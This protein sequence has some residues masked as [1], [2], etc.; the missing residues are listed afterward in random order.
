MEHGIYE[1]EYISSKAWVWV[2]SAITAA[3]LTF[4]V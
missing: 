4:M 1:T 3:I 2:A